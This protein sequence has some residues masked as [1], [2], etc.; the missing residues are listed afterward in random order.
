[1]THLHLAYFSP[2]PPQPSGISAYS[3]RLLVALSQ[4]ASVTLFTPRPEAVEPSL[5]QYA[6]IQPLETYPENRWRYD[7]ALYQM[8]NS[9]YHQKLYDMALRYSGVVVLHDY[10]L[11][12]FVYDHT[13]EV[14]GL[15]A[16]ELSYAAGEGGWQ[17][18]VRILSGEA[19]PPLYELPLNGRLLDSSLGVIVHSDYV[20]HLIQQERP[21]LPVMTI[22]HLDLL[23]QRPLHSRREQLAIDA[24]APLFF[25]G[26]HIT[27]AM[28]LELALR[29]FAQVR[30]QIPT[31]HYVVAGLLQPD[32]PL[33]DWL[34]QYQLQEAVTALGFIPDEE[35][36]NEWIGTA[37]VVV[38]LRYPTIGETSGIAMRAMAA[39]RP[40]IV[41]DHGWYG[42]LPDT[43]CVKVP[44]MDEAALTA[45]MLRLARE[46]PL[47]EQ[48]GEAAVQHIQ[49]HHQPEQVAAAYSAF[50]KQILNVIMGKLQ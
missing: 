19:L 8:G 4:Q 31:A 23:D 16:R 36:F 26:G 32:V 27:S 10:G 38:N 37:D 41:F 42:E 6:T 46:R 49:N 20:R 9:R 29:A 33:A 43:V 48:L 11:H 25:T 24:A 13:A 12:H 47:R 17:T 50:I 45:A 14:F 22:P 30:Q 39:G 5:R 44:V 18:A 2:L 35:V 40:L 34:E 3:Q 21:E 15:Y 1:M 7:M 28:Q